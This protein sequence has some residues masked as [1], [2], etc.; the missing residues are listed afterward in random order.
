MP[1]S[2]WQ[3][4]PVCHSRIYLPVPQ[5]SVSP[6]RLFPSATE[7]A[8][9]VKCSTRGRSSELFLSWMKKEPN[10]QPS[11]G[12]QRRTLSCA[13]WRLLSRLSTV[14]WTVYFKNDGAGRTPILQGIQAL[15]ADFGGAAEDSVVLHHSLGSSAGPTDYQPLE[16][17]MP[18]GAKEQFAPTGGRP[19]D[20][21]M[22][23][24]NLAWPGHGVISF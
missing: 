5:S 10:T 3:T 1:R 17:S 9:R 7:T 20:G 24:F 23:Y 12:I 21:E 16:T 13:A 14:E 18:P 6:W 8:L 11:I 19:T 2:R 4:A 15:D 22:P